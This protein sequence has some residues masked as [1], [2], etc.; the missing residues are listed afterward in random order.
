[1]N[2]QTKSVHGK[3]AGAFACHCV[4]ED[5]RIF[6]RFTGGPNLTIN[7]DSGGT[8]YIAGTDSAVADLAVLL[9]AA[10]AARAAKEAEMAGLPPLRAEV[11]LTDRLPATVPADTVLLSSSELREIARD[12]MEFVDVGGEA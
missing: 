12:A 4:M 6:A 3:V 11:T 8:C 1:M 7:A 9:S 2:W 5:G 10:L